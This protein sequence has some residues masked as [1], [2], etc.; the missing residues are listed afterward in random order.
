MIRVMDISVSR[1]NNRLALQLP[2]ELPLGLVFVVGYAHDIHAVENEQNGGADSDAWLVLEEDGYHLRCVL[3][4]RAATET[5]IS[6]GDRIRAGGHLIFD[7]Q[8]ANY[9]LLARDVEIVESEPALQVSQAQQVG[10]TALT[11]ILAD[12]KK[13]A[14]TARIAQAELPVWVQRM[15]PPEVQAELE[16]GYEEATA[17]STA[18][19][20]TQHE[21]LNDDLVTFLS[22]AIEDLEDVELT[23]E[24]LE[25]MAPDMM[26][27]TAVS[28]P[29]PEETLPYEVPPPVVT[30]YSPDP[31][32]Q[33]TDWMVLLLI[34]S[35]IIMAIAVT[36]A[37]VI[38]L[39][40]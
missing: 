37:I 8:Q 34:I 39:F 25:E 21:E 31:P 13:R 30:G 38:L 35:F 29:T 20:E 16:A 15:A 9:Y 24:I 23:T 11:P 6:E 4:T 32:T 1:L 33:E 18:S 26:G 27:D 10:R 3:S 2:A 17:V 19:S 40:R 28:P 36:I 14:E 12:I 22:D 5:R 7:A